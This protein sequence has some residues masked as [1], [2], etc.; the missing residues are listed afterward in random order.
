MEVPGDLPLAI[1]R[2]GIAKH[3]DSQRL[4]CETPDHSE[5][6]QSGEREDVAASKQN[7]QQLH[8][9]NEIDNAI[10]GPVPGMRF[11]KCV[12]EN[13]IFRD[14]VQNT[15]GTDDRSVFCPS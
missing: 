13:S 4:Q 5:C 10:A 14:P 1:L 8:S 12:G 11:L 7:R 2:L 9:Y 6:I 3:E 15:V